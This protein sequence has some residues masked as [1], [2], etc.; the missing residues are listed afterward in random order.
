M[1]WAGEV[2]TADTREYG[3]QIVKYNTDSILF[4]NMKKESVVWM[5]HTD[6]I[7][8][9]PDGFKVSATT[10]TCPVAAMENPERKIYG[11][12]FHPEVHH[13]ENG[14]EILRAFLYDVCGAIGDWSMANIAENTI[15][16]LR[17]KIGDKKVLCAMSGGVDSAV[18]AALLNKAVGNNLTC[19]Y[20]DHG[21]M[22]K[23]ESKEI[24]EVFI[25]GMHMNL[26]MVDAADRFLSKLKG[27]SDPERKRKL[28]GE[29]FIR[30][31]EDEGKKIGKVDFLAQGTIYPDVIESGSKTSAVINLITM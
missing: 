11:V 2:K 27:V 25:D 29:E 4:K 1:K 9:L 18:T 17:E 6:Y 10:D 12:Q 23:N 13:S 31:F 8:K 15:K 5:S 30:V 16:S 7:S 22:R 20:V 14:T 26:I 19:I 21:L 3:K 24:K 28:I